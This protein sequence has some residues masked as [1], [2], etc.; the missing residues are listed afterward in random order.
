MSLSKDK[1]PKDY[2]GPRSGESFAEEW[3]AVRDWQAYQWI[4]D[5]TWTYSDFDNYLYSM[6]SIKNENTF[7]RN[8]TV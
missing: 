1:Y 4:V 2:K 8:K 6:I 7:T 5:G 3:A